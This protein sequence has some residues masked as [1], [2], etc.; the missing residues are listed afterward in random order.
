VDHEDELY[1]AYRA[2]LRSG[3]GTQ[4]GWLELKIGDEQPSP[5]MY[6]AALPSEIDEGLAAAT[7][8]ALGREYTW[9]DRHTLE[10][11]PGLNGDRG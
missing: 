2:A 6:D 10:A 1:G 11:K 5:V 4:V 9:I 8:A 7:A 3:D